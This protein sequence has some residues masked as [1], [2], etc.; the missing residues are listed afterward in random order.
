MMLMSDA[1]VELTS[2]PVDLLAPA[3]MT[4]EE[5]SHVV[6]SY[7]GLRDSERDTIDTAVRVHEGNLTLVARDL[8]ISRSTLYLKIKKYE[9]E[10]TLDRARGV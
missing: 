8:R 1:E 7:G 10:P 5:P 3:D 2:L 4:V 6:R 9:L